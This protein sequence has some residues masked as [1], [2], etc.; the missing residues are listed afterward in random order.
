MLEKLLREPLLHFIL[1]ALLFFAIY[2]YLNPENAN[3]NTIN[4]TQGRIELLK[5]NF[6]KRWNR[7]PLP[8]EL[9]TVIN[10]YALNQAYVLEAQ[11]LGM[12]QGD[13]GVE[14]RLRQKMDFMIE[15]LASVKQPTDTDLKTFYSINQDNYT[16]PAVYSFE[17]IFI[18]DDKSDKELDKV[19]RSISRQ[20]SDGKQPK[21]EPSML[22][23]G[24]QQATST[25]IERKFGPLFIENLND[26]PMNQ[27]HGPIDSAFGKHFVI[28]HSK[29]ASAFEPFER[30]KD[31]VLKDWQYQQLMEFRDAFEKQLLNKYQITIEPSPKASSLR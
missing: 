19:F 13:S 2:G 17:Q 10:N 9:E 31:K 24:M 14:R 12:N 29:Q 28:V 30:V 1:I 22:P 4:I 23:A 11:A 20:I 27:W 15:D 16:A 21:G 7:E 6:I 25:E 26:A 5:N 3:E 18:A 8:E